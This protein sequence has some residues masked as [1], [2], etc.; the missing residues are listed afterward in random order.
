MEKIKTL[1]TEMKEKLTP[2][3]EKLLERFI[4]NPLYEFHWV[5]EPFFK[6]KTKLVMINEILEGIE[7]NKELTKEKI[8]EHLTKKVMTNRLM[9]RSTC[10][11]SVLTSIWKKEVAVELHEAINLG[12]SF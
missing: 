7:K 1:L 5:S 6:G 9:D 11:V 12:F 8:L 10:Q 2:E 3:V 4:A